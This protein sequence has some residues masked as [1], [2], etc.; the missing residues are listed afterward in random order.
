MLKVCVCATDMGGSLGQK[1][2]KQGSFLADLH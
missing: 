1:V 2:S